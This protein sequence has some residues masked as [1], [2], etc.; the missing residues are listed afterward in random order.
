MR[1]AISVLGVLA[2]LLLVG[3]CFDP[4]RS[5]STDTDCVN[6]GTCDPGT[7]TCVAAGNPNDR[8]P[9]VFS[10][11]VTPPPLRQDT[12]KLTEYDPGSPDGGR[13]AFRR[14]ERVEVTVT[15]GDQDVD[16]GSVKLLAH[17]VAA[18]AGTAVDVPLAPCA[19]SNPAA[20]NPFCR[21]GTVQLAPLPFEAFRAVVALE[22]S[23]ADLSNNVGSAD[24][25]VNVTRW[26][27]RYSAGAPI[28]TTPAIADDGT[29][30]FGT[31]DGGSGSVY[32]LA[33]DGNRE[34]GAVPSWARSRRVR[35]MGARRSGAQLVYIG[36]APEPRPLHRARR[37]RWFDAWTLSGVLGYY[38]GTQSVQ[39]R[40][41]FVSSG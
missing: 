6:G 15:S 30:V 33:A 9:P 8:T 17:G 38:A 35:R 11:L 7:K 19:A 39:V 18:S 12:A 24:G 23:G 41:L 14:D 2:A 29:I 32:A 22:V 13:D 28:Y 4:T 31:S 37:C 16:A 36:T 1:S 10:I 20:S 21:E 34:M 5:C 25:G 26:K 40:Q 27:W 3:A